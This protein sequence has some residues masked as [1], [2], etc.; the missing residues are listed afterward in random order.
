MLAMLP[1]FNNKDL[2][3]AECLNN[4]IENKVIHNTQYCPMGQ[5]A[6]KAAC[7]RLC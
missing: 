2:F 3:L 5:N 4:T 7:Y 6:L 1:L